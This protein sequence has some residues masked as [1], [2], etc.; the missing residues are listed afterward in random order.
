M[1]KIKKIFKENRT[2]I[3][4]IKLRIY[5][6]GLIGLL[7]IFISYFSNNDSNLLLRILGNLGLGFLAASITTLLLQIPSLLNDIYSSSIQLFKDDYFLSLLSVEQLQNIRKKA[8]KAAYLQT[9]N[10]ANEGLNDIDNSAANLFLKPYFKHYLVNVR[11]EI[12]ED[13]IFKTVST[14]FMLIN[15]KKDKLS[16]LQ[17][18][19]PRVFQKKSDKDQVRKLVK[20]EYLKDS[21]KEL[22]D[23]TN[24]FKLEFKDINIDDGS[25]YDVYSKIIPMQN[26][27]KI[28]EFNNKLHM[29]IIEERIVEKED[30]LYI[31]RVTNPVENFNINYSF[32]DNNVILYG[33][34]FG[35]FHDIKDGGISIFKDSNSIH[36]STKKWLL[37]G[38]G[39]F[40]VHKYIN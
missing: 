5:I 21:M 39:I 17:L 29:K 27:D 7:F 6:L 19:K 22:E 26:D 35:T 14:D 16:G 36:I 25:G 30:N 4:N 18:I 38:N 28:L 24:K 20:I 13:K 37:T 8:T 9:T 32:K 3:T 33:S 31:R 2:T 34:A 10:S 1:L 23:I 11:C 40:I 12:K 15:P